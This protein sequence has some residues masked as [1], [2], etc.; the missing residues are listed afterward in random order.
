MMMPEQYREMMISQ[1]GA[2]GEELKNMQNEEFTINPYQKEDSLVKQ[3]IQDLYRFFKLFPRNSDFTDIFNLP[4]NYHEIEPFSSI[5]LQ[6]KN[7]GNIALYYFEKNNFPEAL[8][9]YNMLAEQDPSKG[10]IWQKIGYC[11]QMLADI[12]G[13]LDAYLHADLIEDSNTWLLNRIAHC[14]RVLKEP[15]TALEYYRRLEQFKPDDL[16]I[17]LNIGHCYLELKQYEE[18]LNYYF[19]VELINSNNTRAWRSIAWCAFLSRK[20]DIAQSYYSRILEKKPDAH[21]YL[22][23][24]HVELCLSNNSKAVKLYDLSMKEAG[25]FDTF[26]TMLKDDVDEL[27]EAGVDTDIL[28]II[29]DKILYDSDSSIS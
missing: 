9:A 7:L 15:K 22:N 1:L 14:Y 25:S 4:L 10:E 11:K 23:A 21:D 3:Y 29:V 16:N 26:L 17:Q 20:F 19:K 2:D 12:R 18:A 28:P 5:V 13:A 8:S 27:Q 24:G 6:T